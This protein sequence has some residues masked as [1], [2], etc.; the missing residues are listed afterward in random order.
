MFDCFRRMAP[1]SSGLANDV[2]PFLARDA[3]E[4]FA[5]ETSRPLA[6]LSLAHSLCVRKI[7]IRSPKHFLLGLSSRSLRSCLQL[8]HFYF[9]LACLIVLY[10]VGGVTFIWIGRN[11]IET[12]F[13]KTSCGC[14]MLFCML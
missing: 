14:F 2:I 6:T 4:N 12:V 10:C 8:L 9:I 13:V 1:S 7:T 11:A 5:S 3:N